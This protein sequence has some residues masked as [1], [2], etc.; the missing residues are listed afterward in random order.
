[1]FAGDL[2][3]ALRQI[4]AGSVQSVVNS[5]EVKETLLHHCILSQIVYMDPNT[6]TDYTT[7]VNYNQYSFL[8][9]SSLNFIERDS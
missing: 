1:M 6:K 5:N 8:K 4:Q 9:S 3:S 2:K 7:S